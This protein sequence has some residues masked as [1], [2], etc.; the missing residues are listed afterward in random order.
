MKLRLA[1]P[2]FQVL[3]SRT[4]LQRAFTVK[5]LIL[6]MCVSDTEI[7]GLMSSLTGLKRISEWVRASKGKT[8]PAKEKPQCHYQ[9]LR[10]L[11]QGCSEA[12][13]SL[14]TTGNHFRGLNL[15]K[16]GPELKSLKPVK[17]H[18]PTTEGSVLLMHPERGMKSA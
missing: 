12:L 9:L 2:H 11:K 3:L 1:Q 18:L 17:W 16:S 7:Q 6:L 13:A 4:T 5:I 14:I 15:L 8:E 10:W